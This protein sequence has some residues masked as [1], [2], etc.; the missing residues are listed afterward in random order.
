VRLA[1]DRLTELVA[2]IATGAEETVGAMEV[3]IEHC[4]AEPDRASEPAPSAVEFR[5]FFV[6][7]A[8]HLH[9][10]GGSQEP[11]APLWRSAR[12]HSYCANQE[13][14]SLGSLGECK[15]GPIGPTPLDTFLL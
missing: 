5:C 6:I 11:V 3:E 14:G 7:R 4:L 1:S 9:P 2:E 8:L 12:A 13:V 10:E 15:A